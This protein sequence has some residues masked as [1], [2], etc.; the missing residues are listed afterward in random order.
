MIIDN[1]QNECK[2]RHAIMTCSK[3]NIILCKYTISIV[4]SVIDYL[5][6]RKVFFFILCRYLNTHFYF[7]YRNYM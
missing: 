7:D 5:I 4:F 1:I 6:E 2:T 3:Y